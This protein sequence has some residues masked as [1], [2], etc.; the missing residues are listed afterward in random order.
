MPPI[1]LRKHTYNQFIM[2]IH[3]GY[4]PNSGCSLNFLTSK[5]I[6]HTGSQIL[7]AWRGYM[8]ECDH[9]SKQLRANAELL[10]TVCKDKLQQLH[11]DKQR[12]RKAY[13]EEHQKITTQF[14]NVCIS[15]G[16]FM[17]NGSDS[18]FL[19]FSYTKTS[20][21]KRPTTRRAWTTIRH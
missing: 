7:K 10:E 16:L 1:R 13:Q 19:V 6:L 17:I 21:G 3:Y 4:I 14:N 20:F 18:G 2:Y 5:H 15:I 11:Q 8:E 12:A 9:T